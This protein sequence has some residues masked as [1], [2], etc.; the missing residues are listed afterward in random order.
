LKVSK[1]ITN[2]VSHIQN[3]IA[4]DQEVAGTI[5]DD[6]TILLVKRFNKMLRNQSQNRGRNSTSI[7]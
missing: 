4:C 6:M 1:K 3:E 5:E 7:F 2:H